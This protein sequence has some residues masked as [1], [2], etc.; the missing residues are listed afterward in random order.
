VYGYSYTILS[1]KTL[2]SITLPNNSNVG[3][4]GKAMV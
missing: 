4:L 1:G 3:I 2:T